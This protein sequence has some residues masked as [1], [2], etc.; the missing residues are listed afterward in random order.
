MGKGISIKFG[1]GNSKYI[2]WQLG[3]YGCK[4]I[5]IL[6]LLLIN[7]KIQLSTFIN[8]TTSCASIFTLVGVIY[9]FRF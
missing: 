9:I 4:V 6:D 8:A 3:S 1:N 5:F 2:E 7:H